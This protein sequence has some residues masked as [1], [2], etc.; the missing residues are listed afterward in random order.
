MKTDH[1]RL[2]LEGFGFAL[3]LLSVVTRFCWAETP[4]DSQPNAQV[5]KLVASAAVSPAVTPVI[6]EAASKKDTQFPL[7]SRWLE[8]QTA[9]LSTEYR[10]IANSNDVQTNSQMLQRDYFRGRLKL[11]PKGKYSIVAGL[12]TGKNFTA[13]WTTTGV[14]TG[15]LVT[16]HYLKQLFLSVKPGRGFE[17]Q[18][19]GLDISRG[20]STE[21]TS[22]DNDGYIVGQRISLK[23]PKGF[24]FDEISAT[25]AYLGDITKPN[26]LKRFYRLKQSNYHQFL[27]VKN[28]NKRAS[29]S[30]DYSS[31][32]GIETLRE[33]FKLKVSE[34]HAIDSLR[35]ENY[36]RLDWM[37]HYGYAVSVEKTLNK[38]L[39][40]SGGYADID[41]DYG[42]LNANRIGSGKKLF[43][44]GTYNLTPEFGFS[45]FYARS[46]NH[47]FAVPQHHYLAL[48]FNYNLLKSLQ[49]AQIL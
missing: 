27:V 25:Y 14:G 17:F 18:Y 7:L 44:L 30:G 31:Q 46:V 19:G 32:S 41:K 49:R 10:M 21:I 36:Q 43:L 48:I 37:P 22:Y 23:N 20:E 5:P 34:L 26:V 47:D 13:S 28:I 38:K 4:A 8:I 6:A 29:V 39:N 16:N 11:D 3:L 40:L 24:F 42:G 1:G 45:T 2:Y 12:F 15:S 9:T 33:A 35:F